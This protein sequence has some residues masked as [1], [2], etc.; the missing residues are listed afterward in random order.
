MILETVRVEIRFCAA[1]M[2]AF[3]GLLPALLARCLRC[4]FFGR[5]GTLGL[6]LPTFAAN[7]GLLS[8]AALTPILRFHARSI[9]AH[10]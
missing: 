5:E 6:A 10:D 7:G 4:C 8:H 2:R 3:V 1:S 9:L